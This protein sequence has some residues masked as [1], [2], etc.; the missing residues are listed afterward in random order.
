MAQVLVR[1]IPDSVME[2]HKAKATLAG[3]SLEQTIRELIIAT[4]PFSTAERLAMTERLHAAT[5]GPVPA[6]SK[7]EIREGLE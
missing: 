6:L 5:V 1:N 2:S 7:D 3:K 4:A